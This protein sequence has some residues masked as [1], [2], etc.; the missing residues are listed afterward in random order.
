MRDK[1][2][3]YRKMLDS[4]ELYNCYDEELLAY[5]HRLVE[6]LNQF[7]RIPETE[8][9]LKERDALLREALG[10]YGEGLYIIPPVY[11]NWGLKNVHVGR[12]VFFNF[13]VCLVDDA[14]IY[15]GDNC[16]IGPGCHIVTAQ[17]PVSP[18]LRK[19][20]LQYNKPVRLGNNVWL[21]A[22]AV[23][24]P[25]VTI[26]DNSIVGAGSVVTR[27]VEADVIVAGSPARILRRITEEDNRMYDGGR[28][29][30]EEIVERYIDPAVS[31][32]F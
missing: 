2:D 12:N 5:Q 20:Q 16:Q 22:G 1:M 19:S 21:G 26:G 6:R 31:R 15:I 11:A 10:T 17:H 28:P 30:P 23:I 25:G 32:G 18:I 29:V 9:G 24:L 14:D 4:G 8:D 27:D 13:N 3:Q 7:N